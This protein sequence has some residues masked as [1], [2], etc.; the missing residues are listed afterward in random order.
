MTTRIN[1]ISGPRN[2]STALMYAFRSRGDTTVIDEPLFGAFLEKTG[3]DHPGRAET[4]ASMNTDVQS[5]IHGQILGPSDSP[6]VFIKNMGH[7][8]AEFGDWSWLLEVQNVFLTRDPA[9]VLVSFSQNVPN[10]TIELTG[11]QGQVRLQRYLREAGKPAPVFDARQ[12]LEDPRSA[13]EQLCHELDIPW[14]EAMLSWEPGPKPEDG[15]WGEFWYQRAWASTGFEPYTPRN[16][17]VPE[18]LSDLLAACEA[19]Y[20]ELRAG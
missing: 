1:L 2:I 14:D 16:V 15:A 9:E 5:V 4:I 6:I 8:I 20:S 12:I 10:P 3:V 11:F 17:E 7:H 13:L 19:L 18:E